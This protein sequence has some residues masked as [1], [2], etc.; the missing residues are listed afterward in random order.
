MNESNANARIDIR[1]SSNLMLA[2]ILTGLALLLY[3]YELFNFSL[4]IDEELRY[5]SSTTLA[6]ISQGRFV[7]GIIEAAMPPIGNIPFLA[8]LIFSIGLI[9]FAIKTSSLLTGDFYQRVVF[10]VMLMVSPLWF[11]LIEFNTLSYGVGIG[12][13]IVGYS[14]E[15]TVLEQLASRSVLYGA[16]GVCAALGI[17]QSLFMMFLNVSAAVCFCAALRGD[18]TAG[19]RLGKN[20]FASVVAGGCLYVALQKLFLI[21]MSIDVSYVNGF[22][23]VHELFGDQPHRFDFLIQQLRRVFGGGP[24]FMGK[25]FIFSFLPISGLVYSIVLIKRTLDLKCRLLASASLICLIVSVSIFV[26]L[27]T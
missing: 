12:L 6:W 15:R 2:V 17:Y 11:H 7:M 8:P 10:A 14:L 1:I 21:L 23:R 22:V 9:T 3:G 5:F 25:G 26:C 18:F 13:I 19:W 24:G 27:F 20:A 4:S 16:L